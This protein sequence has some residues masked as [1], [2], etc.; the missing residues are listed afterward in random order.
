[1]SAG[2]MLGPADGDG[3]VQVSVAA[4]SAN[5]GSG[6]DAVGLALDL[7]DVVSVRPLPHVADV[8]IEV[9]GEGEAT[10]PRDERHLIISVIRDAVVELGGQP[11]GLHLVA[12]NSIPHGRGLGSSAAAIVAG[13]ALAHA[14]VRAGV[15]LDYT[16]LVNRASQLEGH[17]DNATAAVLGGAILAFTPPS[18][19]AATLVEQLDLHPSVEFVAFVPDFEV[20]TSG[21]RKVLPDAVPRLDAVHQAIRSAFLPLALTLHPQHLMVATEDFLH[22]NYRA[23]LM[24][25]SADLV[26]ALRTAGVPAV[27][28]GA[29]P[30]VLALGTA[31]QLAGMQGD[32]VAKVIAN[33]GFVA[34]K[35]SVGAGV[36]INR[37]R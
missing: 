37:V 3:W 12:H 4:S 7:R 24:Q 13:L 33:G 9:T 34:K 10:V 22:Q 29:G 5:L 14:L 26:G 6:F 18:D 11:T 17:P 21:A 36:T 23:E 28:S 27:I 8:V 2:G 32:G 16:W 31:E 20:A 1:M 19:D 35:L 15:E 25:P 30:T